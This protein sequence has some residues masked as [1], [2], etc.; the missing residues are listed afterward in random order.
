[1]A[2]FWKPNMADYSSAEFLF[3]C[4]NW[5]NQPKVSVV[6]IDDEYY[7]R[8][9]GY[10]TTMKDLKYFFAYCRKHAQAIAIFVIVIAVGILA[11]GLSTQRKLIISC[12]VIYALFSIPH[13]AVLSLPYE[14]MVPSYFVCALVLLISGIIVFIYWLSLL[15]SHIR[16][17]VCLSTFLD[18][19][20]IFL[21]ACTSFYVGRIQV[22]FHYIPEEYHSL[23][24]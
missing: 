4:L 24:N 21:V 16:L 23:L 11:F 22:V 8:S 10:E 13:I 7:V 6:K 3:R 15:L 2:F 19:L 1:M 5:N 9:D 20:G 12:S 17:L 18:C 14:K